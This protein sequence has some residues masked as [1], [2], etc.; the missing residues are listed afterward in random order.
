MTPRGDRLWTD[1]EKAELIRLRGD[2]RAMEKALPHRTRVAIYGA[3]QKLGLRKRIKFWKASEISLLRRLFPKASAAEIVEAFPG[4]SWVNI[5]QVARYHGFRRNSRPYKLTGISAL[6]DV[7]RRCF[8]INWTMRDLDEAA[9]TKKYFQKSRWIRKK[10]NH[11][12]LGRA[13]EALDGVVQAR[14]N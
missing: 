4:A 9:R 7:R 12:A 14:W 10:I 8:E 13:I 5:Q 1:E 6:D 3:C 2:Y 11:R